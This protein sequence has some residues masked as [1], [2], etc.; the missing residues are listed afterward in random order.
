MARFLS[1]LALGAF[2]TLLPSLGASEPNSVIGKERQF[3]AAV[4]EISRPEYASRYGLPWTISLPSFFLLVITDGSRGDLVRVKQDGTVVILQDV[5]LAA[6]TFWDS[7]A[8]VWFTPK[9][10][11]AA[12]IDFRTDDK[13]GHFWVGYDG[14]ARGP[15]LDRSPEGERFWRAVKDA[16]PTPPVP[17]TIAAQV[18]P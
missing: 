1:P 6:R 5:T 3:W 10:C 9:P 15:A 11:S 14:V 13:G 17:C 2:L 7:V 4:E 8:L 12:M 18:V 16:M